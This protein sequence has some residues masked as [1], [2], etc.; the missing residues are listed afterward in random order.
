M[1]TP[2]DGPAIVSSPV[3]RSAS[4]WPPVSVIVFGVLNTVLSKAI[5]S[6]PGLELAGAIASR[7]SVWPVTG[8]VGGAVDD[9]RRQQAAVLQRLQQR[10]PPAPGLAAAG[11]GTATEEPP[12]SAIAGEATWRGSPCPSGRLD[13]RSKPGARVLGPAKHDVDSGGSGRHGWNPPDGPA[14]PSTGHRTRA[15]IRGGH[16][17][18][19]RVRQDKRIGDQRAAGR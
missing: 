7:R 17:V 18:Q 8:V 9:E 4:S 6:A 1:V 12:G 19:R 15:P 10:P 14:I 2:T 3:C 16:L 5:V 11:L 13:P